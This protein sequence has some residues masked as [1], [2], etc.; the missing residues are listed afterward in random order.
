MEISSER[1]SEMENQV[2]MIQITIDSSENGCLYGVDRNGVVYRYE[3]PYSRWVAL[4]MRT[5]L[6]E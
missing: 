2:R 6:P 3:Y 5:D 1:K 4:R